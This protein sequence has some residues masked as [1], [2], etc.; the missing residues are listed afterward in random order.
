[1][2]LVLDEVGP[3][4]VEDSAQEP[5]VEEPG[6]SGADDEVAVEE[7]EGQAGSSRTGRQTQEE[8]ASSIDTSECE[9][10]AVRGGA[11]LLGDMN[12]L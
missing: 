12:V 1:M 2:G 8:E 11:P 5:W 4:T 10:V 6:P 3:L 7:E 9:G